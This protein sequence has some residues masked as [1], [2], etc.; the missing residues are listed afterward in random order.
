MLCGG[1][2]QGVFTVVV[3]GGPRLG[4]FLAGSLAE[5]TSD[6]QAIAIGGCACVIAVLISLSL[7][8]RFVAYDA[9]RPTP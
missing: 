6:S 3:T 4:D 7:Q 8:R 9:H 1:R 5:L 2:M